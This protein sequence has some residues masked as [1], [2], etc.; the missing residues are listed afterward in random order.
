VIFRETRS[1]R[2]WPLEWLKSKNSF[3]RDYWDGIDENQNGFRVIREWGERSAIN[4]VLYRGG[5]SVFSLSQSDAEGLK[6][7]DTLFS[8]W[9]QDDDALSFAVRVRGFQHPLLVQIQMGGSEITER[10]DRPVARTFVEPDYLW[11]PRKAAMSVEANFQSGTEFQFQ[12]Q[13]RGYYDRSLRRVALR[14]L[15][16]ERWLWARFP[17][18]SEDGNKEERILYWVLPEKSRSLRNRVDPIVWWLKVNHQGRLVESVKPLVEVTAWKSSF[19]RA[20][21]SPK[22]VRIQ[23]GSCIYKIHFS[24][25]SMPELRIEGSSVSTVGIGEWGM[26][27]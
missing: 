4:V 21:R 11:S 25:H 6:G 12:F 26:P 2:V 18:I 23:E 20:K 14:D 16:I 5:K 9:R 19:F 3:G 27:K 7:G 10:Q 24:T 13:G 17:V 22:E 8:D 1:D 15:G